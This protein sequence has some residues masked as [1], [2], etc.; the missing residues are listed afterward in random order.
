MSNIF[1]DSKEDYNEG[2]EVERFARIHATTGFLLGKS[3]GAD[4]ITY[5]T[6]LEMPPHYRYQTR[7]T[8]P[9][10]LLEL[11]N[12]I[13]C[14]ECGGEYP[15]SRRFW[16]GGKKNPHGICRQCK[17]ELKTKATKTCSV[18][19]KKKPK[20]LA[21]WG[22]NRDGSEGLYSICR[23]CKRKIEAK[24]QRTKRAK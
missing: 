23:Q 21:F 11:D 4:G 9:E 22:Q 19:G 7:D 8:S 5:D 13:T 18:C 20:S 12:L 24:R 2:R 1:D 6:V 14:P 17:N 15:P 16:A 10:N 3:M